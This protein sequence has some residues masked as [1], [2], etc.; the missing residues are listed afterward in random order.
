MLACDVASDKFSLSVSPVISPCVCVYVAQ[1]SAGRFSVT[2]G[3]LKF[4]QRGFDLT[5]SLALLPII[6]IVAACLLTIVVFCMRKSRP[7]SVK[8]KPKSPVDISYMHV[9]PGGGVLPSVSQWPLRQQ[10]S[11]L[12]SR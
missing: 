12:L 10:P 8:R 7:C 2:V 4:V 6:C 9:A 3:Y 5:A 1:V 11:P